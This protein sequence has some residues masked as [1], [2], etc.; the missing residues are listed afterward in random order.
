MASETDLQEAI[1]AGKFAVKSA[2]AGKTGRMVGFDCEREDG[3]YKCNLVLVPLS[4]AANAEKKIPREWINKKGNFVNKEFID[5]AL[6]LI[7]GEPVRYYED[8][9][10]RYAKLNKVLAEK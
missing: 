9:L 5:Y 8:S 7:Q 6:P 3:K 1:E 10:P 2:L 4:E